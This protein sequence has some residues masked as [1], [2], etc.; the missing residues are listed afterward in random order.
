MRLSSASAIC[1]VSIC[2]FVIYIIVLV[3]FW[4]KVI[5]WFNDFSERGR[6]ISNFNKAARASFVA[7]A[8]PTLLEATSSKGDQ[9]Y[10][11]ECSS[12]FL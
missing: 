8:V 11:H 2:L 6:L 5:S 10:R 12:F 9:A 3:A 1:N 4:N 7:L